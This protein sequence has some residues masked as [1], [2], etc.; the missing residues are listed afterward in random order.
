M[1]AWRTWMAVSSA[2][3]ALLAAGCGSDSSSPG[4]VASSPGS[5]ASS[6][7][8]V[9]TTLTAPSPSASPAAVRTSAPAAAKA[10][11]LQSLQMSTPS[12][13]WALYFA[14][15]PS[16]AP[17]G[18]PTLL[19]RTTDGART[20]T[21]VT[22]AAA[23]ELL[24]T[25]GA[26]QV[27]DAVGPDS[28]YLAVTASSNGSPL[29]TTRVFATTDGGQTWT[30]SA[31][32]RAD[33]YTSQLSFT[34]SRHGWLLWNEGAAMGRNPVR[35]YRTTDGGAHWS[36]TAQPPSVNSSNSAAGIPIGCDKTG[37][38][39]A[40][41]AAGWMTSGCAAGLSGELLVSR[42][43]GVT[44]GTQQLPVPAS[45]CGGTD[46][47]LTG[48]EFTD[49]TGFVTVAAYSGATTLLVTR[50]LG[51]T[52]LPVPL[53]AGY[54]YGKFPYPRIKFFDPEHGVL[55]SA[56]SQ[57]TIG[58]VFYTTS[59]GGQ[60]WAAVP[61]GVHFTQNGAAIDFV[62]PLAGFAWVPGGD[63]QGSSPPPVYETTNSGR[64][65]TAF[66]PRVTG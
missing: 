18:T 36:L 39:F 33:G 10:L 51:Q 19:V 7:G 50:D 47:V 66:N 49:G 30:E 41:A 27:L 32:I 65:W 37:I 14:G 59:D 25:T 56:G 5:V 20:W 48:P 44:W 45:L 9:A 52:W 11:W 61:Q 12:T 23:V 21:D 43:G 24:S 2:A 34:D 54:E 6:P 22:P 1:S 17:L 13:G 26:S 8:S 3:V 28:A 38:T 46:C 29:G 64:T 58:T 63:T 40:S 42:D 55:V 57:G 60:T 16:T 53:P 15:N 35:V 4:S 62:S 31:S